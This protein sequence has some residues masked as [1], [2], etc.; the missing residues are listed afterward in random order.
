MSAAFFDYV[1]GRT[2]EV[3]DGY[4][5]RGL[6]VYRYLVRLGAS[7]MVS[8]SFPDLRA[9][10]GES[11]WLELIEDFVKQSTWTSHFYGDLDHEFQKYLASVIA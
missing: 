7:Q 2:D 1:R 4:A 5:L 3:P 6:Q 10:L 9:Q 11:A 8:A